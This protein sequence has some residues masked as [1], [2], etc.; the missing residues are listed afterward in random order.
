MYNHLAAAPPVPLTLKPALKRGYWKLLSHLPGAVLRSRGHCP[1]CNRSAV[2]SAHKPWLR[3]HFRCGNCG[4]IPR[5]RALMSVIE[6]EF[7]RWR[8]SL[9]HESSPGRRGASERLRR[10]CPRYLATQYFPGVPAGTVFQGVRSENL[11]SLS[12]ADESI[13]LH[14]TQDVLEH[15]FE[16]QRVFQEMARTLRPGG[17]HVFTVPLVQRDA[18]S[19]RR[20]RLGS[21]NTVEHLLPP[22]YHGNPI[23]DQGSLVTMDWG[24]DI[25]DHIREACGLETDIVTLDDLSLGI[26]AD[27]IEVLVT[28]KP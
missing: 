2:F 20:A 11:E 24:F 17:A 3:D 21:G 14:V 12:F 5:E 15:V 9:I 1:T 8:E 4:S 26:R 27:Y 25:V 19:R 13:D 28:H 22:E 10:E 7:P 6:R 16:P 18:P 23:S